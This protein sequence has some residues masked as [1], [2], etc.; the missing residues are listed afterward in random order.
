MVVMG[1]VAGLALPLMA[2]V[3]PKK[4]AIFPFEVISREDHSFIGRGMGKML[5]T[6]VGQG[7]DIQVRCLD[8]PFDAYQL[9]VESG[10][11]D[12]VARSEALQG[13]GFLLMGSVTIAGNAVSTDARL[14]DVT[15]EREPVNIHE[16][17][18]GLGDVIHHAS[19]V[20]AKVK[21]ALA[22]GTLAVGGTPP[23]I[24]KQTETSA[25][26]MTSPL[27]EEEKVP[28]PLL[29]NTGA[30][31][32]GGAAVV[33]LS[34]SHSLSRE[35]TGLTILNRNEIRE[36]AVIDAQRL[37][38]F[39]WN[40]RQ[41]VKK[42]ELKG[43]HYQTFVGAD[44]MDID[45]DGRDELFI[46]VLDGKNRLKS[47]VIRVEDR[48][49]SIVARD[50]PWFFRVVKIDGQKLLLGQK[51]GQDQLFWG[52]IH[53]LSFDGRRIIPG[54]VKMAGKGGILGRALGHLTTEGPL[55]M[56]WF[57]GNGYLNVGKVNFEKEWQ[58]DG[59]WGSTNL[60]VVYDMGKEKIDRRV[61]LNS[62]VSIENVDGHGEVI[63][64]VNSDL[65]RGL[66][67]GFRKFTRGYVSFLKWSGNA[68]VERW[69]TNEIY[70]YVADFSL[71]DMN[72]DGHPEL[73]Y[74]T[75]TKP[76]RLIGK[77]R[78]SIVVQ[79]VGISDK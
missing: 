34:V 12:A 61:Y 19:A 36:V 53:S 39:S 33:P 67:S 40:N 9:P 47:L 8:K 16:T 1:C 56:V 20:A 44:A 78:S 55:Q 51:T 14:V 72:G 13:V 25:P 22:G 65:A 21:V 31:I 68:L 66:L 18:T 52:D 60:S 29:P 24:V 17:G 70:G 62:R 71:G 30:V 23:G 54:P 4:I 73:V 2:D 41:L 58:S 75:V 43:K 7:E 77:A 28:V 74:A 42:A 32:Q 76:D 45:A 79:S 37:A 69:K 63:A 46:T 35:I 57:D 3:S 27:K 38:V 49:L 6:R 10:L 50:L 64:I 48:S 11:M 59:S 15:G 5:C 26:P